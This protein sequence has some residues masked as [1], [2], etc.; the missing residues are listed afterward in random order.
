M[1]LRDDLNIR[2]LKKL[3]KS[4][5]LLGGHLIVK[6]HPRGQAEPLDIYKALDADSTSCFEV[7]K[8][9]DDTIEILK[10]SDVLITV[11]S[12][13]ILEALMMDKEC[14]IGNY[15][16]GESRLEYGLYDAVHTV[17]NEEELFSIMKK[18]ILSKK[19]YES[20]QRLLEDELYKLDGQ[21]GKRAVRFIEE[22]ISGH[23]LI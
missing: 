14:V 9:G 22:I 7:V 6:L 3:H 4:C 1:V 19:N 13:V 8:E 20:K 23:N 10:R 21:A 17:E 18:A 12:T 15:L 2:F 5:E 11:S 16:A